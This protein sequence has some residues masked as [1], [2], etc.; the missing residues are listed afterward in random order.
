MY[1]NFYG[2]T[3]KPFQLNPDPKF[4]F[5]SA[6][7]TQA[8]SYLQ[9]GLEQGEGFIVITGPIGTGKTMLAQSLLHR[10]KDSSIE[11]VQIV[12]TKLSPEDLLRAI[13][14]KF[15]MPVEKRS[16][17]SLLQAIEQHL[18]AL[19]SQGKRALLLVDEAQNLPAETVEELRM[20][21][22]FQRNNRPLLQSFLL[23]QEELKPIIQSQGMEQFR[24]RIIASC[25]LQPLTTEEIAQYIKHRLELVSEKPLQIFADDCYEFIKQK[26]L[27]IPR[28]I[29]LFVDRVL[30]YGFLNNKR[31]LI[32]EDLQAVSEEFAEELSTSQP[33]QSQVPVSNEATTKIK[34][35]GKTKSTGKN[36]RLVDKR[37]LKSLKKIADYLQESIDHK[38]SISRDLDR[39]IEQK[40]ALATERQQSRA[41]GPKKVIDPVTEQAVIDYAISHPD[42][43]QYKASEALR[44]DGVDISGSAIRSIWLKHNLENYTKRVKALEEKINNEEIVLNEDQMSILERHTDDGN[45]RVGM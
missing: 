15:K 19:N 12:T 41:E 36:A 34:P 24:Q 43:G 1:E 6:K 31:F 26:T 13:A 9:Y 42:D 32:R 25:H 7:H 38:M 17:A 2:F 3:A 35:S 40:V 22:N 21:S 10:I 20:L 39:L 29:N 18:L 23:G 16:K 5:G 27:G 33:S 8:L 45:K 4:F 14:R 44:H 28:K 37:I 11:A 30:L